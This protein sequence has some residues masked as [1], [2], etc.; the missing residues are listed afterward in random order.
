M[1]KQEIKSLHLDGKIK[2]K[3]SPVFEVHTITLLVTRIGKRT[4]NYV[5]INAIEPSMKDRNAR[6]VIMKWMRLR[7]VYSYMHGFHSLRQENSIHR[8]PRYLWENSQPS[9]YP[10][11]EIS[12]VISVKTH[13]PLQ[14]R[15]KEENIRIKLLSRTPDKS[16]ALQKSSS[17]ALLQKLLSSP[18]NNRF[19]YA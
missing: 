18:H 3:Q 13:T 9:P 1:W 6:C 16:R 14:A 4:L 8:I 5:E 2:L 15:W 17:L 12:T 10:H 19:F 7:A 11:N